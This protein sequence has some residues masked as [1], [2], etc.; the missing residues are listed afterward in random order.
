MRWTIA[1]FVS[2]FASAPRAEA[3]TARA[4][5]LEQLVRGAE[6]VL[7][8]HA[9]D[10]ESYWD[11]GRIKTRTRFK[12]ED[13]W[14]G[15]VPEGRTEVHVVTLGG[16]VGE[17]GQHVAGVAQLEV[18][19]RSVLCLASLRGGGFRAVGMS[20]GVFHVGA[21]TGP[22]APVIRPP[23]RMRLVGKR[24]TAFPTTLAALKE[25]VLKAARVD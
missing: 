1:V 20:Q 17:I 13:V 5:S 3:T 16:V 11:G 7:L 22:D 4:A 8:G 12:I 24:P 10:R 15:S 21:G 14:V 9:L 19:K 23:T 25:A 2:V 18:G 6:L